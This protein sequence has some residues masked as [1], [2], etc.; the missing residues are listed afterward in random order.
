MQCHRKVWRYGWKGLLVGRTQRIRLRI[1][2]KINSHV[3]LKL[4]KKSGATLQKFNSWFIKLP[5][6]KWLFFVNCKFHREVLENCSAFIC[7][8]FSSKKKQI[9][10]IQFLID[11]IAK[12]QM[13]FLCIIVNFI[14]K[15]WK[16]ARLLFVSVSL[17][18]RNKLRWL[19]KIWV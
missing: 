12:C 2:W 6:A 10:K 13:A 5:S 4:R 11:K 18:W 14:W 7:L 19:E 15:F 3:P 16:I 17:V 1:F 9:E 8:C